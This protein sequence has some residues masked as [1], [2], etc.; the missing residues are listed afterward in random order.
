MIDIIIFSFIAQAY[1]TDVCSPKTQE[2]CIDSDTCDI[3]S[4][5][6]N[7]W[8]GDWSTGSLDSW[9]LVSAGYGRKNRKYGW[10]QDELVM[11]V[12]YPANSSIPSRDPVGGTGFY[13]SPANLTGIKNILLEYQVYFPKSFDFVLVFHPSPN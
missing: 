2:E 12:S 6:S 11:R 4:C 1:A 13:A 8:R 7:Q 9:N 3:S 10:F 5:F